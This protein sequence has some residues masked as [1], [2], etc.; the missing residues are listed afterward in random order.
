MKYLVSLLSLVLSVAAWAEPPTEMPK[1]NLSMDEREVLA[2]TYMGYIQRKT[3]YFSYEFDFVT[4][5]WSRAD[6]LVRQAGASYGLSEYLLTHNDL[7]TKSVVE[8]AIK[9]YRLNTIPYKQGKLLTDNKDLKKAETGATALALIGAL[10][11]AKATGDR[12]FDA[13]I[14]GWKDG[15]IALYHPNGGFAGGATDPEESSYFNGETWLALAVYVETYPN[16]EKIKSIMPA[17]DTALM[18]LYSEHPDIG[19]FHWGL[20]ATA[21]RYEQ[22][23]DQKFIDF[24]AQQVNNFL[25]EMR[26]GFDE[27]VNSCYSVEGMSAVLPVLQ[28]NPKNAALATRLLTRVR[29]EMSK[30]IAMQI[31]PDQK[32]LTLIGGR[33]LIAPEITRYAGAFI[34]GLDR[35]QI[36]IDFTQHCLSAMIKS[37]R[38]LKDD[39][40]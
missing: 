27:E 4:G 17:I 11:Y 5:E 16:D 9:A 37:E 21:R 10:Q 23:K 8:K 25:T 14:Q 40:K 33:T 19:F 30:N 1:S 20:M 38:F 28:K 22:T 18:K 6:E 12:Q 3:G 29:Q 26:P 39:Q 24:G 31:T 34:N 36:R 32:S 15:L 35:P 13:D 2:A 7:I